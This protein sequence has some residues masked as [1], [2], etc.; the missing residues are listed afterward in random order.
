M[1][2]TEGKSKFTKELNQLFEQRLNSLSKI[3][4]TLITENKIIKKIETLKEYHIKKGQNKLNKVVIETS[5]KSFK[6]YK[7]LC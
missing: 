5:N 4:P 6:S 1:F 2:P 7:E 3:I